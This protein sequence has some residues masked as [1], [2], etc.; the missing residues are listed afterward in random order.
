VDLGHGALLAGLSI[1]DA[2]FQLEEIVKVQLAS[3]GAQRADQVLLDLLLGRLQRETARARREHIELQ[4]TGLPDGLDQL[5]LLH[6]KLD[7]LN[8]RDTHPPDAVVQLG[9]PATH[10]LEGLGELVELA[11]N[12]GH[13][14]GVAL[15]ELG[16]E[17]LDL[18]G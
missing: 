3:V 4:A 18:G 11:F 5:A 13:Q 16:L 2:E 15:A 8:V 10:H 17:P 14:V 12:Q 1:G 9:D 6:L 7:A